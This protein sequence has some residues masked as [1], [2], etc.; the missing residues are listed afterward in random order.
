M[1]L[2]FT[3][4]DDTANRVLARAHDRCERFFGSRPWVIKSIDVE[5]ISPRQSDGSLAVEW[6]TADVVASTVSEP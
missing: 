4:E 1:I 2:R 6:Y 5:D 3:V